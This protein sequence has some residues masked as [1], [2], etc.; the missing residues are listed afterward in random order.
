MRDDR[1]L[2]SAVVK[3]RRFHDCAGCP[4][5]LSVVPGERVHV[6]VAIE[7]GA[8]VQRRTCLDGGAHCWPPPAVT[9]ARELTEDER[10]F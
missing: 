1:I 8:L 5:A 4:R 3:A 7:D 9:P 2:R 6:L 10:A